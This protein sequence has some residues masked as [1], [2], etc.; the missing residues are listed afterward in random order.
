MDSIKKEVLLNSLETDMSIIKHYYDWIGTEKDPFKEELQME[1][2]N[3]V[4]FR[5]I[6]E[7]LKSVKEAL[8]E[9]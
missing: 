2:A 8:E 4:I 3:K 1:K 7:D 5:F 6:Y 9:I